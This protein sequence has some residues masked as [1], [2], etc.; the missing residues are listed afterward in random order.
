MR[1]RSEPD[2]S[3]PVIARFLG[4]WSAVTGM[5]VVRSSTIQ[6]NLLPHTEEEEVKEGVVVRVADN[7]LQVRLEVNAGIS[8]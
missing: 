2:V 8:R 4:C 6:P 5:V 3:I 7:P 1:C